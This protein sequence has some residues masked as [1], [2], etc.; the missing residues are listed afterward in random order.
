M[1]LLDFRYLRS[2]NVALARAITKSNCMGRHSQAARR[3]RASHDAKQIDPEGI[4]F[5]VDLDQKRRTSRCLSASRSTCDPA[6]M[7][8]SSPWALGATPIYQGDCLPER[9]C[10]RVVGTENIHTYT[11]LRHLT[12]VTCRSTCSETPNRIVRVVHNVIES[13]NRHRRES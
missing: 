4:A 2:L 6:Y 3:S 13:N 1:R 11:P 7:R 5:G 9:I 12:K 10:V 8:G